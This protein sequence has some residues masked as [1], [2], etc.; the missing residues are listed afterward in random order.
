MLERS[1]VDDVAVTHL[2]KESSRCHGG[3]AV[4]GRRLRGWVAN[5]RLIALVVGDRTIDVPH[6][7]GWHP[8]KPFVVIP[9]G[10]EKTGTDP[11]P[12]LPL[13]ERTTLSRR[14]EQLAPSG[15]L[16]TATSLR[17]GPAFAL[18]RGSRELKVGPGGW[19]GGPLMPA[20]KFEWTLLDVCAR[21]R[22]EW[23]Y[24]RR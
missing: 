12:G 14:F 23:E 4:P 5:G 15:L 3:L 22:P 13:S 11:E 19:M 24:S 1:H 10:Y 17:P 9:R 18:P 7:V 6:Q 20:E 8:V 16:S 21:K 2:H